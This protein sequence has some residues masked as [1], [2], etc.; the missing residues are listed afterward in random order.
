MGYDDK[1]EQFF[2]SIASLYAEKDGEL[3]KNE[4]EQIEKEGSVTYSSRLDKKI[5]NKI[6]NMKIRKLSYSLVPIAA[7]FILLAV[8]FSS[9]SFNNKPTE[10]VDNSPSMADSP[11]APTDSN[12]TPRPTPNN[13]E[14][15][16]LSAK[17]PRGY[18]LTDVDYDNGKTIYYIVN[19]SKNEIVLTTEEFSG[20]IENEIFQEININN[21]RVYGMVKNDYSVITYEKDDLLYTLTS[22]YN[23]KDLIEIS[24]G[25]L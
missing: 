4:L 11:S 20:E 21:T 7:C 15:Q 14:V 24:K 2:K 6:L 13:N 8:Y 9:P 18:M 16:L 12:D 17:L 19:E 23:Y 3:L 22:K 1:N 5:K 25:L 10:I